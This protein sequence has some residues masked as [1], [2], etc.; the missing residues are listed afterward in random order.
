MTNYE[1]Q[2][3]IDHIQKEKP[4]LR[5]KNMSIFFYTLFNDGEWEQKGKG[6]L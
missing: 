2:K 4:S 5:K 1:F 6:R 3:Y